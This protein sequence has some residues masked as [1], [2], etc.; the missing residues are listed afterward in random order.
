MKSRLGYLIIILGWVS[1]ASVLAYEYSHYGFGGLNRFI[2]PR[3]FY[4]FISTLQIAVLPLLFTVIGS[5]ING[6][7]KLLENLRE[8][9]GNYRDLYENAPV[10]YHSIGADT[11]V[12]E[13]NNTWLQMFG[14]RRED[15]VGKV[16]L[17]D[18]V[19]DKYRE[20]FLSAFQSLKNKG[21]LENF[22]YEIRKSDNTYLP[23]IV[24]T[25]AIY[26]DKGIFL[27]NQ[28]AVKDNS[29]PLAYENALKD[30]AREWR[31]T[32][33]N[34]PD[35]IVLLDKDVIIRKMNKCMVNTLGVSSFKEVIGKK[36]FE[37]IYNEL[38]FPADH[39]IKEVMERLTPISR[40]VFNKRLNR[41]FLVNITPIFDEQGEIQY[42]VQTMTDISDIKDR[43]AKLKESRTAFY[44]ILK[45]VDLAY[46]ELK[47]L[48]DGLILALAKAVDAKSPWT[49]NHSEL[50]SR[51]S[52]MIGK[53][54][55]LS[56]KEIDTLR[57]A[58]ILH[59]IGKIGIYDSILYKP[60]ILTIDE[61]SLIKMHPERGAE[62]VN[63]IRQ[64]E[65]IATIM[66]Y[67]HERFDGSGYPEGL[68]GDQIP[69]FSR[70]I[71]VADAYEAMTSDRPYRPVL[72]K[73]LAMEELNRYAGSQFDPDLVKAFIK[74][75][76]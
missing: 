55:G 15:I 40:E 44:N 75:L 13:V 3:D 67:H 29:I 28:T 48:Q 56:V 8:A 37:V 32:F 11:T 7:F 25:R 26:N 52:V 1:F 39:L 62:I 6:R 63:H 18:L 17:I 72:G 16:R 4:E 42:F 21:T 65:G 35:G 68:M 5:I 70:I 36:Y 9:E 60:G 61:Y 66:K 38:E 14:F 57:V 22:S 50:V 23:V 45:D 49:K 53:E 73:E 74:S 12:L 33:D 43:E 20:S 2:Y 71:A 24:N 58:A 54:L 51:Y 64:L 31:D 27:K 41:H 59:D 34:M 69:F 76:T 19:S 47:E 30:S 10:G 46:K